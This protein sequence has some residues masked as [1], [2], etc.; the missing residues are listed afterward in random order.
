MNYLIVYHQLIRQ[1]VVLKNKKLIYRIYFIS[2]LIF[3]KSFHFLYIGL[4][5]MNDLTRIFLFDTFYL[6]LPK[7]SFNILA[8][9]CCMLIIFYNYELFINV[10]YNLNTLLFNIIIKEDN[11]F[12]TNKYDNNNQLASKKVKEFYNYILKVI[13]SLIWCSGKCGQTKNN[14]NE[15]RCTICETT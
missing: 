14:Y 2:F 10:D 12:F 7:P 15:T 8:S 11:S 3:L 13:Q 6:I 4:A 1:S 5:P 9:F